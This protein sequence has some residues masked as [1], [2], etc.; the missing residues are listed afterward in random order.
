VNTNYVYYSYERW[1]RGYIGVKFDSDPEEDEY[2]GSFTDKTFNPTEK[3]VI[4]TFDTREE[5]L[6]A[7]VKLHEFFQVDKNPH[8]ANQS[9]QLTS[10]FQYD[11]TGRKHTEETKRKISA[12]NKRAMSGRTG[13]NHNRFGTTHSEETKNK[14]RQKA[15]GRTHTEETKQKMSKQRKGRKSPSGENSPT[16]GLLW[17]VNKDNKA[18]LAKVCPGEEWRRGRKW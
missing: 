3:V 4:A 13:R 8:F 1:N 9:K 11:A 7:E 6:E 14:I 10:K 5:A 2:F 15:L 12:G 16:Y 17:W 18:M